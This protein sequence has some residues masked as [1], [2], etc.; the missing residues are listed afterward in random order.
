[1]A[2]PLW[3]WLQRSVF[4]E[5]RPPDALRPLAT[6]QRDAPD[7]LSVT[8]LGTAGFIVRSATTS[9]AIDP[10]LTR[11]PLASLLLR[12]LRADDAELARK[13]PSRLDAVL[14]GHSHYDH[15]LDAPQAAWQSGATLYGS[16]TTCAYGR[17]AGLSPERVVA[18][19]PQGG[20]FKVGDLE[21]RFVPSL[22]AALFCG[23]VPFP[24]ETPQ[25]PTRPRVWDFRMGGAFGIFVRGA[26]VSLY[27][28][29]SAD[30]VDMALAGEH[31]DVVLLGLAG[32][33]STE[34]YLPRLLG[35][36]RPRV[37]VPAHH[38]AFFAPLDAGVRLLPGIQFARFLEQTA[39]IVPG[40]RVLAPLY[41]ETVCVPRRGEPYLVP[42]R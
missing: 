32:W 33:Q 29:G 23:H 40:A 25:P 8:W 19:G 7:G 28:N 1:L 35:T 42:R 21:V 24:G 10:Y 39:S 6:A 4:S 17:Q 36:L 3:N 18:V 37:V 5:F 22:H 13:L 34:R 20:T 14:C 27:H 26:G 9:V 31:A 16:R 30:L 12:P 41:E 38:D 11:V 2:T 15:L